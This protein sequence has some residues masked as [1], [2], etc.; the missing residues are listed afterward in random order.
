RLEDHFPTWA[1]PAEAACGAVGQGEPSLTI[2]REAPPFVA[3]DDGEVVTPQMGHQ[4]ASHFFFGVRARDVDPASART[5]YR[6]TILSS[7]RETNAVSVADPYDDGCGLFMIPFVLPPEGASE[8][9]MRLDV[10]VYD[11]TENAGHGHVEIVLAEP[12]PPI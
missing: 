9:L 1:A 5:V 4:G 8:E 6:G 7:G 3:L 2:G 10:T 12:L 11:H